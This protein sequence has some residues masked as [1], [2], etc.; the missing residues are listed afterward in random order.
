MQI[1]FHVDLNAF[2]A[3]AE[4]SSQP[5]LKGKPIVICR[6]SRRS[7]ITTASYEAR[8][9]GIHSAMPLFKAK[10][11]CPHLVIVP[12]HFELYKTLSEKFFNIISTFSQELEVASIDECYVDLTNY[13]QMH[14]QNPYDVAIEIQKRVFA[15]LKLQCSIGI[16]PNKFLAK[17]ASDM[18]K[19]MGITVITNQNYKQKIWPLP[20]ENMFGIGKKTAPKLIELGIVRIGD[21]AKYENYEKIKPIFGKNALIYYQKANG[22]DYSKINVAHNELKSIGNSTTFERDSQD[23]EFIKSVFRDLAQ[24][25]SSRAKKRDLVGNSISI[26]LKY[27]R[28]KS[29][30]KQMIID[31]YTQD[32]DTIYATSLLLFESIYGGEMLR[33]VG[34]SLNNVKHVEELQQ[35]ISLFDHTQLQASKK[36]INETDEVIHRLNS[37]LPGLKVM[38]A[39]DLIE[40]QS[41]IQKKYLENNE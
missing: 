33:L 3:S 24:E 41:T 31:D 15:E 19:P 7:I 11:L 1:I 26:T 38:K 28:E 36:E 39:S 32:F 14:Y 17:M 21:L 16:A 5:S 37:S 34:I 18:Q 25:V 13:I 2:Y 8:K 6:E 12:P 9:F 35:Q 20:I 30:T 29:K 23:E 10:E 40:P 22:K 4:T 27:T